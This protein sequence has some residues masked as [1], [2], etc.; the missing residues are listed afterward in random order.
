MVVGVV[1]YAGKTF[2]ISRDI[3]LQSNALGNLNERSFERRHSNFLGVQTSI[4][5]GGI[6]SSRCIFDRSVLSSRCM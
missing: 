5:L 2:L 3:I 4:L 6:L 1:K